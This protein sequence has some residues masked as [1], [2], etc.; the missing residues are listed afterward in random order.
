[1]WNK[2]AVAGDLIMDAFAVDLSRVKVRWRVFKRVL[3]ANASR[4]VE[5]CLGNHDAGHLVRDH[6]E[7]GS[8][9]GVLGRE[10]ERD[11]L[12]RQVS[13]DLA[14]VRD[15][16]VADCHGLLCRIVPGIGLAVATDTFRLSGL[17]RA[18]L[19]R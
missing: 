13:S 15:V 7:E 5:G 14:D 1:M 2:R 3:A 6:F 8:D 4:P 11:S 19:F 12:G 9:D 10:P 18:T 17:G 16:L